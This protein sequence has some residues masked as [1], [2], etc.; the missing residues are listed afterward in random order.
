MFI[1][2]DVDECLLHTHDKSILTGIRNY[3]FGERRV[4]KIDIDEMQFIAYARPMVRKFLKFCNK[5]FNKVII[6]SAGSKNYV[7]A[8][9]K[10]LFWEINNPYII[11]TR[12]DCS[13]TNNGE[14]YKP[15]SKVYAKV[16]GSDSTN[17]ILVD[18]REFNSVDDPYNIINIPRYEPK[19]NEKGFEEDDIHLTDIMYWFCIPEVRNSK[20]IKLVTKPY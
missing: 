3:E 15:L 14:L 19:R 6:W 12:D 7:D 8:I 1:V 2:L 5:Y 11:M 4:L 20:D 9:V 16:Q 18:D 10:L 17:T 13:K